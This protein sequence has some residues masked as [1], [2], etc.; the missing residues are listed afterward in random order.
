MTATGECSK[1][2]S[3]S[4]VINSR[5]VAA[6]IMRRREC[7]R[8]GN[9]WSTIEIREAYFVELRTLA[10]AVATFMKAAKENDRGDG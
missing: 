1:C 2:R 5:P 7:P 4:S 10:A 8:C 3:P 9:R 6:Y